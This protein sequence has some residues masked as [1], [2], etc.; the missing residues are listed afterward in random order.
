M[1]WRS[2]MKKEF[3][4]YA[5]ILMPALVVLVFGYI[6]MLGIV[7]A[8]EDFVPTSHGFIYSLIHSKFVGLDVF[9]TIWISPDAKSVIANT[10]FI[11]GMKIIVKLAVPLVFA[12]L[13]NEVSKGWFRKLGTTITYLPFFLS[14]VVVGGVLLDFFSPQD[15]AFNHLL[16]MFGLPHD[17]FFFGTA[18]QFP[19]AIVI[20][21]LWKEVGFNTI[22]FLAA[23]TSVDLTMY[24]AAMID[25]AGR[26]KQTIYLTI[27]TITP[28]II[29]VG[30]LSLGNILN[31][32]QDQILNLY[33][34]GV[35]S[36]GDII[37]TYAF[38]QGIQQ[39][40]FSIATAVGL[41]KSV[42]SFLMISTSY[43]L[44]NK[45]TDYR[46]F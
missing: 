28:M 36:S 35:Y 11:A 8:F 12:L 32:G 41:F 9:R 31:A 7:M 5:M 27:P 40:E 2:Q 33:S 21:D 29:L 18:T 38:R 16:A 46:V 23:L 43:W 15:G 22:I 4:L 6:P 14:W 25:G 17:T 30:I 26:W 42:V 19:F 39:G 44:A 24:E 13:L 45:F 20:S 10:F 3:S 34:P 1:K 37:D